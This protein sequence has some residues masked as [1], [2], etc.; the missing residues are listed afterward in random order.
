MFTVLMCQSNPFLTFFPRGKHLHR[1]AN[2]LPGYSILFSLESV[3]I[4]NST[5]PKL[6]LMNIDVFVFVKQACVGFG[7]GECFAAAGACAGNS[8]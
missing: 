1:W 7:A 4:S 8:Y 5:S 2:T 6:I 3:P